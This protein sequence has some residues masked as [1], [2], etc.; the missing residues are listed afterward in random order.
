[1]SKYLD[2]KRTTTSHEIPIKCPYGC[3]KDIAKTK[4]TINLPDTSGKLVPYLDLSMHYE[5]TEDGDL[6]HIHVCERFQK[7]ID[8][9]HEI[10]KN[11]DSFEKRAE[12]LSIMKHEKAIQVIK[13]KI[14]SVNEPIKNES[15]LEEMYNDYLKIDEIL[16]GPN[17]PNHQ[18]LG[19]TLNLKMKLVDAIQA[20][21]CHNILVL[22]DFIL[23]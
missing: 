7:L 1:M 17:A 20:I 6:G 11:E 13:E 14:N 2:A 3:G 5:M 10:A 19:N 21:K 12:L 15:E 9:D 4:V 18:D 16:T 22:L 23:N 8:F